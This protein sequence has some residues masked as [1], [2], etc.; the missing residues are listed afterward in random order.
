MQVAHS[1]ANLVALLPSGTVVEE[2]RPLPTV[3]ELALFPPVFPK[4]ATVGELPPLGEPAPLHEDSAT[5]AAPR[6]TASPPDRQ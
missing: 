6:R 3:V 4:L 5:A 1:S 2:V